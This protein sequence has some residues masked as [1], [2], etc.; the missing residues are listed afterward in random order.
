MVSLYLSSTLYHSIKGPA[1]TV[2]HGFD[3]CAIYLL[4]AGTFM[5]F[6]LVTLRG[7]WN[8]S[9]FGIIWALAAAGVAKNAFLHGRYRAVSIQHFSRSAVILSEAKDPPIGWSAY[10]RQGVLRRLHG[11]G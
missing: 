3:H 5:R 1:N 11:S 8:W 9:L 2:F 7:V 10:L 4:I 6:T